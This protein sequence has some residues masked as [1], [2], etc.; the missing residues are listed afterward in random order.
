MPDKLDKHLEGL[1]AERRAVLIKLV[2]GAAFVIPAITT[3][4]ID[5]KLSVAS[6]APNT[7]LS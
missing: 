3:F 7:T 6:A 4:A 5:G 1:D 2:R